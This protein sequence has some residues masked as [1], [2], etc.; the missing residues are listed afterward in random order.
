MTYLKKRTF[1]GE[2]EHRGHGVDTDL[3]ADES[4]E[5]SHREAVIPAGR[6][7]IKAGQ[8]QLDDA[9]DDKF[10]NEI[11]AVGNAGNESGA[12]H[13]DPSKRQP[14][15]HGA[16]EQACHAKSDQG[17]LPDAH[18]D[19]DLFGLPEIK[20]ISDKGQGREPK[21]R[22]QVRDCPPPPRTKSLDRRKG[23]TC[24]Q[25]IEP[26]PGGV[27]DPGLIAAES[28]ARFREILPREKPAK[29]ETSDDDRA[30]ND[31]G[32]SADANYQ[33][34]D[35]GKEQVELV[36]DRERPG[37]REGGA[38]AEANVLDGDEKLPERK[39]F[40]ILTPGGQERVNRKHD[41]ISRQ[42]AQGAAREKTT[43]LN[44]FRAGEW[45]QELIAD[46]VTAQDEEEIDADPAEAVEVPRSFEAEER[47]VINRN[48]EDSYGAEKIKPGLA[49]TSSEARVDAG[50][51][52][53]VG[54]GGKLAGRPAD[55]KQTN[56]GSAAEN[57]PA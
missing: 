18:C 21:P 11:G 36:F 9:V 46:Q 57:Q 17:E 35:E 4:R 54:D 39:H 7:F 31:D 55:E 8:A 1:D 28:D 24:D 42:N 29:G 34:E 20:R 25:R 15:A 48:D 22:R 23:D 43:E 40:R 3:D 47:G 10:L 56:E 30:G 6:H 41:E 19:G 14:R 5:G 12:G 52:N 32:D 33:Q 2:E 16:H 45:G 50:L 26:G 38:S 53:L 37:M 44:R 27:V 13:S 49:L 51:R